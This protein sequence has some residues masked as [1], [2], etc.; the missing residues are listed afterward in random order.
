[1]GCSAIDDDDEMKNM[2]YL[3]YKFPDKKPAIAVTTVD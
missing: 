2:A 1:L 3:N